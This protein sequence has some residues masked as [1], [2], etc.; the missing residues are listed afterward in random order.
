MSNL[1]LLRLKVV[2]NIVPILA[3]TNSLLS[4]PL[5]LEYINSFSTTDNVDKEFLTTLKNY[6]LIDSGC[7]VL[8]NFKEKKQWD[9]STSLGVEANKYAIQYDPSDNSVNLVSNDTVVDV[10]DTT[11]SVVQEII[12]SSGIT[13]FNN[14]KQS[15]E[16][17]RKNNVINVDK[18][19]I[20]SIRVGSDN[21]LEIDYNTVN[22][23]TDDNA[24][25]LVLNVML[26]PFLGNEN[27]LAVLKSLY[28][29]IT[30]SS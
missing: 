26:A 30:G 14:L 9:V 8:T 1:I 24:K 25:S 17:I 10:N 13:R 16:T 19:Q 29:A 3:K 5:I 4:V 2:N 23:N 15:I 21:K 18:S 20:P 11:N 7:I 12:T 6:Y 22:T 28:D 27:N